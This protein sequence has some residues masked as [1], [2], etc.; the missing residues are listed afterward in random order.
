MRLER[1]AHRPL[2]LV[3]L[4]PVIA[5]V[6]ALAI[7]GVL[8][9]MAGAPVLE[10]YRLILTGAFGTRLGFTETLTRATP[11]MLTGLAAAVAFLAS[12]DSCFITASTFMDDGG[13]SSA[14]VT[15]L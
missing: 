12:D 9:A 1:R 2:A 11:L 4:A 8:I 10:A 7:A 5:I 15:P 14:Y 13:I 6:T 3:L